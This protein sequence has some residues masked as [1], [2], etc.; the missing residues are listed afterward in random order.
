MVATLRVQIPPDETSGTLTISEFGVDPRSNPVTVGDWNLPLDP[1]F[2]VSR[3]PQL[4]IVAGMPAR[5]DRDVPMM[6]RGGFGLKVYAENDLLFGIL[7]IEVTLNPA[8]V[9]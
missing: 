9:T 3:D 6:L 1:L 7:S 5:L 8:A 2:A 4:V